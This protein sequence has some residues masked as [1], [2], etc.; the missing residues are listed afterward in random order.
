MIAAGPRLGRVVSQGPAIESQ[1]HAMG[2]SCASIVH[3][4]SRA[5]SSENRIR[6]ADIRPRGPS[7]DLQARWQYA[8]KGSVRPVGRTAFGSR[9]AALPRQMIG[10]RDHSR[11]CRGPY[12]EH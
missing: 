5:G 1:A 11:Q 8:G 12:V 3:C 4:V 7:V 6:I 10:L 2:Q 9:K